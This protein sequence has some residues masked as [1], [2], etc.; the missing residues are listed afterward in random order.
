[1]V[2][3][4]S[5]GGKYAIVK[6]RNK[7]DIFSYEVATGT[8]RNISAGIVDSL[9]ETDWLGSRGLGGVIAGWL[10]NEEAVLIYDKHDIWMMELSKQVKPVNITKGFGRQHNIALTLVSGGTL[11]QSFGRK[12]LFYLSA[13]NPDT[14]ECGFFRTKLDNKSVIEKLSMGPYNYS[15]SGSP[16]SFGSIAPVIYKA[17]DAGVYLLARQ[18]ATEAPNFFITRDFKTFTPVSDIH[19]E[20]EYNWYTTELHTWTS[21]DG[22]KLQGILYKPENFDPKK[23]YPVLIHYYEEK[24]DALNVYI[25][26]DLYE[27]AN[28]DIPTFVS[29]GYLVFT[30]DIYYTMGDAMQGTYDAVIS[31]A[32]YLSELPFVDKK[33]MGIQGHSFGGYETNYLVTHS[34]IFAAAC[35]AAGIIDLIS[36]Y[37]FM[38][39][40]GYRNQAFGENG[41][42]RLGASLWE[43]PHIYIKNSP[44]FSLANVTTPLLMMHTKNDG[45]CSYTGA[46]EM[47]IGLR[48]LG[49]KAWMLAYEG[50]HAVFGKDGLDFNVRMMQFFDHYLKD[51]PAPV[52][53]TQGIPAEKRGL[54]YGF[55]YDT[56][57]KTPGKG[58]LTREEQNKVDSI[59]GRKPIVIELK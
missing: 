4:L 10:G 43:A 9:Q 34:N 13:F 53:M 16:Y 33:K 2:F 23:K 14:K 35:S 26:P 48:R 11:V 28:I 20:K 59:I 1:D 50:D 25:T 38:G 30:P 6:E 24:S 22:R 17:K 51:K 58:L 31:G 8:M 46:M 32:N 29:N 37:G 41:Q 19:P 45:A 3:G 40:H 54:D 7:N 5:P 49:K 55:D 39:D 56:K 47:F 36:G 12:E 21:L 57:I 44:I 15:I 52:W 27:G 42:N 18:T